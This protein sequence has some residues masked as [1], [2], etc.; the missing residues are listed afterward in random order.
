MALGS[1]CRSRMQSE[2]PSTFQILLS[3]SSRSLVCI[4]A[5]VKVQRSLILSS[6]A[7]AFYGFTPIL[8]PP[9]QSF[10]VLAEILHKSHADVLIAPA[11][12]VQIE[13]LAMSCP[14]LKHTIWVVEMSSRHLD[15][16]ATPSHT[17]TAVEWHEVIRQA[18]SDVPS[19]LPSA[20]ESP[21]VPNVICVLRDGNST[22]HSAVEYTQRVS[23]LESLR[24]IF[25]AS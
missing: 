1:T 15:F 13:H 20:D 6:L 9:K 16:K 25:R 3:F 24:N 14:N 12:T 5:S 2:L 17:K 7:A 4:A 18:G 21:S 22:A 10:E 8:I 11:G 23:L 19:S